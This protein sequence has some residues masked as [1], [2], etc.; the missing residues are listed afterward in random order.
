[1]LVGSWLKTHLG[2]QLPLNLL[3]L[4]RR[5]ESIVNDLVG[6]RDSPDMFPRPQRTLPNVSPYSA[7]TLESNA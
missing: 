4:Y 6:V 7:S 1:M 3:S 2:V 5:G